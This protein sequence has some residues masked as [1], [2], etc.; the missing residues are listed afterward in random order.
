MSVLFYICIL[1]KACSWISTEVLS[2]ALQTC[3][4]GGWYWGSEFR[5]ILFVCWKQSRFFPKSL[6]AV[7]PCRSISQPQACQPSL[8]ISEQHADFLCLTILHSAAVC[9]LYQTWSLI[10][11]RY[12]LAL[13]V[14]PQ[15]SP[16]LVG[17]PYCSPLCDHVAYACQT[18]MSQR[19]GEGRGPT[20]ALQCQEHNV[21]RWGWS[22][23]QVAIRKSEQNSRGWALPIMIEIC[24]LVHHVY[25]GIKSNFPST[26]LSHLDTMG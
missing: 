3:S 25:L 21:P 8:T 16:P 7:C 10:H 22:A 1:L 23:V 14:L 20:M 6:G 5:A 24:H 4:I 15:P 17:G 13:S 11:C 12:N 9:V 2:F 18:Q 19:R 26:C